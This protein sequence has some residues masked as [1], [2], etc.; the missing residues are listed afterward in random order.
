MLKAIGGLL[1]WIVKKSAWLLCAIV[2]GL[3]VVM[4]EAIESIL[5]EDK[6]EENK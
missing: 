3:W 6:K 1:G 2:I 5:R 4:T